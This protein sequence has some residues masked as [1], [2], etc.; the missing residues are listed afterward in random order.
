MYFIMNRNDIT[1]EMMEEYLN[2]PE[3][4]NLAMPSEMYYAIINNYDRIP[5]SDN[6]KS[7]KFKAKISSIGSSCIKSN[8]RLNNDAPTSS[9]PVIIYLST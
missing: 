7:P 4:D 3:T 5:C 2:N 6:I 8:E 9:L 1:F